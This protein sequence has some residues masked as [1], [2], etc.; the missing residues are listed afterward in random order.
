MSC[1]MSNESSYSF[2]FQASS[3][4]LP[5]R[6]AIN[7]QAKEY[8]YTRETTSWCSLC[9]KGLKEGWQWSEIRMRHHKI[10]PLGFEEVKKFCFS[11]ND[12][13]PKQKI[14]QK[15]LPDG[16]II[17]NVCP[18]SYFEPTNQC[19]SEDRRIKERVLKGDRRV[20]PKGSEK[21]KNLF[22]LSVSFKGEIKEK[23]RICPA[24][25]VKN[26]TEDTWFCTHI[27]FKD[28]KK[29]E[30]SVME[31]K[32]LRKLPKCCFNFTCPI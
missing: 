13:L 31:C 5:E 16:R 11:K 30:Y 24:E 8:T 10:C 26:S 6:L 25:Y 14:P 27:N 9:E 7:H 22:C 1:S 32:K 12:G 17:L 15:Q 4:I 20:C 2:V 28:Y 18:D 3:T 21:F 23:Q 19:L 29:V